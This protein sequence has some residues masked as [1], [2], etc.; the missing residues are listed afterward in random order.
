MRA[1]PVIMIALAGCVPITPE[2]IAKLAPNFSVASAKSPR[3][4][5]MCV[6]SVFPDTGQVLN[7]GDHYWVT[8][9]F[10]GSTIERW[11]FIPAA[12]GSIA[13]RRTGQKIDYGADRVRRCA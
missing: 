9:Q 2:G 4:F 1:A 11:D 10:G 8:R 6:A 3:D 5:A 7:D 12:S 13:E